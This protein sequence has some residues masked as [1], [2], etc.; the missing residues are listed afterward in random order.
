MVTIDRPE[1]RNAVNPETAEALY[2]AFL[3]FEADETAR[4]AILTG[5]GGVFCAGFDL[6]YA[7]GGMDEDWFERH[8]IR[9]AADMDQPR[10]GPMGP[11][12]PTGRMARSRGAMTVGPVTMSMAPMRSG[13]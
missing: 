1:V 5:G 7:A 10:P 2:D 9:D 12:R 6:G 8:A 4:V 3:A 13:G 11:T